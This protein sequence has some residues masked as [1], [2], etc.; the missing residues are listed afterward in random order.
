MYAVFSIITLVLCSLIYFGKTAL[1]SFEALFWG[2]HEE[3]GEVQREADGTTHKYS[4]VPNIECYVPQIEVPDIPH[5][6]IACPLVKQGR[7]PES[8][9][10]DDHQFVH[11]HISWTGAWYDYCL[12]SPEE[13]P[14][15]SEEERR[16]IFSPCKYY[17]PQRDWKDGQQPWD[18]APLPVLPNVDAFADND[19][20]DNMFAKIKNAI[21]GDGHDSG[22]TELSEAGGA[23]MPNQ[24]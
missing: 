24:V 20:D 1:F 15:L 7:A 3:Q 11:E 2:Q 21:F 19:R 4:A 16:N 14:H 22:H 9:N 13:F 12:C 5:P 17:A 6:L 8:E 18:G 10:L 23:E